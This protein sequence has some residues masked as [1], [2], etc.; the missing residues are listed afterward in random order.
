MCD[1]LT[2]I[3]GYWILES[4]KKHDI[5]SYFKA[6]SSFFKLYNDCNII[7][8]YDDER[9]FDAINKTNK[10]CNLKMIKKSIEELHTYKYSDDLLNSC[11]NQDN[12]YLI[13]VKKGREKGLVHYNREYMKS[14]E[15]TYKKLFTIWTSK[16]FLIKECIENN[17]FNSEYFAWSDVALHKYNRKREIYIKTYWKNRIAMLCKNCMRYMGKSIS[18]TACYM[19]SD[20]NFW[21]KF[22]DLY[23]KQFMESKDSNY[24][25]DEETIL[26][27]VVSKDLRMV[28]NMDLNERR[29]RR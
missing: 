12:E 11:K 14:G 17:I 25:H 20:I 3:T 15:E 16:L 9:V 28:Y 13:S 6:F 18:I 7:F 22:I 10:K 21:L 5:K 24:A 19:S 29:Q 2:I 8:Y 23:E 4:N 26:Y 1:N 27:Q